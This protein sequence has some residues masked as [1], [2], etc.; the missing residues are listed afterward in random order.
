M[1]VISTLPDEI[2]C[3][4]LS[5]L[6]TRTSMATSVLSCRWC[7]L[8]R[9]VQ[10]LDLNDRFCYNHERSSAG[11]HERF[12]AFLQ[13]FVPLLHSVRKFHL[14]LIPRATSKPKLW[15]LYFS[16]SVD[17]RSRR[18]YMRSDTLVSLVLHGNIYLHNVAPGEITL[19][20]LKNLDMC[21]FSLN[22]GAFLYGCPVL[23]TLRASLD[24]KIKN[25]LALVEHLALDSPSLEYLNLHLWSPCA[26]I[27]VC[28][29]PNMLKACLDIGA[30]WSKCDWLP[31]LL[32]ALC[33]TKFL[34]LATSTTMGLLHDA[35]VLDLPDFCNLIHLQLDF[36]YLDIRVI[37][38]LH[39]CPKLQALKIC[40]C[41]RVPGYILHR[42]DHASNVW[43]QPISIPNCII[44]HLNTVEYQGYQNTAEEQEFTSYIL[45]RGLVLK[46]MAI[47]ANF[48]SECKKREIRKALSK[49]PRG[50]IMCRLKVD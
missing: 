19:P 12:L 40:I 49:I 2:L 27:L 37:D 23:E 48:F 14:D 41:E 4:I 22:L 43:T 36:E 7:Y 31:K 39:N 46:T 13:E 47:H 28:D 42:K 25:N 18:W 3:H 50:S 16:P 6:P 9:T 10:V 15:K 45:Q 33:K 44:S 11:A 38:M 21:V 24:Y 30:H 29:Y 32:Q 8:W 34:R 1:D 35:P 5:F 26:Q 17:E 20:S